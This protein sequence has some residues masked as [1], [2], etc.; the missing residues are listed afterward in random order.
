MHW[1][2]VTIAS[3]SSTDLG[4]SSDKSQRTS[5]SCLSIS[6]SGTLEAWTDKWSLIWKVS[7]LDQDTSTVPSSIPQ[8]KHQSHPGTIMTK[9]ECWLR[10]PNPP[11]SHQKLTSK[12]EPCKWDLKTHPCLHRT[13]EELLVNRTWEW[14]N[15]NSKSIRFTRTKISSIKISKNCISRSRLWTEIDRWTISSRRNNPCSW[16]AFHVS[17]DELVSATQQLCLYLRSLLTG[18]ISMPTCNP[19]TCR[20]TQSKQLLRE[21]V[22]SAS[23]SGHTWLI[24]LCFASPPTNSK[25][26]WTLSDS[27]SADK[28]ASSTQSMEDFRVSLVARTSLHTWASEQR[29]HSRIKTFT[30]K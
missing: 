30:T 9:R 18:S 20:G 17:R 22:R 24:T 23:T 6:N 1:G 28:C 10:P 11:T 2:Q 25:R 8:A 15:T 5:W 3:L 7:T 14:A 13:S 29:V 26:S 12:W 21:I 19:L 16:S 4:N 27:T